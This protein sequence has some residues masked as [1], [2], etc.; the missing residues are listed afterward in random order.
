MLTACMSYSLPGSPRDFGLAAF[1]GQTEVKKEEEEE[2]DV[3]LGSLYWTE[4]E[5]SVDTW[6]W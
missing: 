5:P 2:T 3:G 6:A 1:E 4:P